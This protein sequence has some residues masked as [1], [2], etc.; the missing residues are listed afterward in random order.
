MHRSL[1]D[2]YP[3]DEGA[4]HAMACGSKTGG[5]M[6]SMEFWFEFAITY[7]YPAAMRVEAAAGKAGVPVIWKPFLL[8]PIFQEKRSEE[9]RVGK[10]RVSKCRSRWLPFH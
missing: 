5:H 9:R 1:R 7:S 3:R 8:G 6:K 2:R 10:E 4:C